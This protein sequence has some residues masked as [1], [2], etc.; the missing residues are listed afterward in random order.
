MYT[1]DKQCIG[2]AQS[3]NGTSVPDT[4]MLASRP[5]GG[6]VEPD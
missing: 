1:R 3:E 4:V 2:T 5:S 6:H